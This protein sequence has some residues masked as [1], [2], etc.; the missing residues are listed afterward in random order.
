MQQISN[1]FFFFCQAA[2]E[3]DDTVRQLDPRLFQ[4]TLNIYKQHEIL[5]IC[6]VD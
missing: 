2:E 3:F 6:S 5:G 1:V 4:M